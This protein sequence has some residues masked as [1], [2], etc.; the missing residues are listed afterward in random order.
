MRRIDS[1]TELLSFATQLNLSL[2]VEQ[3]FWKVTYFKFEEKK[4][5]AGKYFGGNATFTYQ[6]HD[7]SKPLQKVKFFIKGHQNFE[8]ESN[9]R[10]NSTRNPKAPDMKEIL[11]YKILEHI[12]YGP[13]MYYFVNPTARYGLFIATQDSKFTKCP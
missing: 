4:D 6:P 13:K 1:S 7:T 12:G 5:E 3:Y 2:V 10:T 11:V 8:I 9:R